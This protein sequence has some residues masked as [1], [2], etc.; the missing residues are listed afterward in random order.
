MMVFRR[1]TSSSFYLFIGLATLCWSRPILASSRQSSLGEQLAAPAVDAGGA[2]SASTR[3]GASSTDAPLTPHPS[4]LA[5]RP[6]V[7]ADLSGLGSL[8]WSL[9]VLAIIL[10]L[11]WRYYW[12]PWFWEL[13]FLRV[14]VGWMEVVWARI[15]SRAA[16]VREL[17]ERHANPRDSRARYN[18]G[19]IYMKQRRYEAAAEELEASIAIHPDRADAQFR[20]GRCLVE[21]GRPGEAIPPLRTAVALRPDLAYGDAA[22]LLASC[23]LGQAHLQEAEATYRLVLQNHPKDAEAHLGMAEI[24]L[25]RGNCEEAVGYYRRVLEDARRSPRLHRR[26]DRRLARKAKRALAQVAREGGA[27]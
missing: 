1:L 23:Y 7:R 16:L 4:P 10:G 27:R 8:L 6:P 19:V 24:A 17:R 26:R 3:H 20:L 18:L 21:L 5:P 22:L 12:F 9:F 25:G 2:S 14:L 11:G 13:A 15:S